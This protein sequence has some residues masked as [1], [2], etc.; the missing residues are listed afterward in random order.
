V[1]F[2]PQELQPLLAVVAATLNGDG[3]LLEANAGFHR[4]MNLT[5]PD[6]MGE[7][8][9]RIF[10]QPSFAALLG[11]T[12]G[13]GEIYQGL[14]TL[15][16]RLG[17]MRTLRGRVWRLAGTLRVV[18]EYDIDEL[19]RLNEKVLELNADYAN[20]QLELAQTNLKLQQREAQIVALTLI[21]PLTG[22]GNRRRFDQALATEVSRSRRT[23]ETLCAFM[24]DLDHFKRV[25]DDFGHEAGDELLVAFAEMLRRQTRATEVVA[26]VGGEE[27][28]V[29]MPHT[30]LKQG[31]AIAE[32]M[33]G[34]TT[35]VRIN[36]MPRGVTASFG[37]A[38]LAAGEEASAF[39]RRVDKALYEAKHSGRDRVVAAAKNAE[40]Q[41]D[42]IQFG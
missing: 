19:E 7:H 38:E 15:G 40:L 17:G 20:A 28:V 41:I 6:S 39:M 9:A 3:A 29:L 18:A 21:D 5:G 16:D 27:F 37:V 32:R 36:S 22:L 1:H 31:A 14:M 34:M 30:E 24:A 13:P 35:A 10:L 8:A 2:V 42:P 25:N 12:A 11:A 26:R 33:R 4:I 23:G